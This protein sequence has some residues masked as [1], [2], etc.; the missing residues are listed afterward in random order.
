MYLFKYLFQLRFITEILLRLG[1]CEQVQLMLVFQP[2]GE[3]VYLQ[4]I[5]SVWWI[6]NTV[7]KKQYLQN[8]KKLKAP[9]S[10][11][12]PTTGKFQFTTLKFHG[13]F[14]R[15]LFG[16]KIHCAH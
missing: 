8:A 15:A 4:F 13:P 14:C 16:G 12:Y 3:V 11:I 5:T 6:R 7:C 1:K 9:N 2:A 10:K